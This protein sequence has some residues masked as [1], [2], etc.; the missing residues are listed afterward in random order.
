MWKFE[1]TNQISLTEKENKGKKWQHILSLCY[2]K[3]LLYQLKNLQRLD[4]KTIVEK[5]LFKKLSI[6]D[7]GWSQKLTIDIEFKKQPK[8]CGKD[9]I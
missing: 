5:I 7:A 9:L 3:I 2:N 1:H 4:L 8:K 6:A